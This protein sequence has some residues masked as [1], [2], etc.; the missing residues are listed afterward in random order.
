MLLQTES[1]RGG[2]GWFGWRRDLQ[3]LEQ[4]L[5]TL[6]LLADGLCRLLL[7]FGNPMRAGEGPRQHAYDGSVN[8]SSSELFFFFLFSIP[9]VAKGLGSKSSC[10]VVSC[11]LTR[12]FTSFW[13]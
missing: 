4:E 11:P 8:S 9:R 2:L 3:I 1:A 10:Q 7:Q 6:V 13:F 12:S 5:T